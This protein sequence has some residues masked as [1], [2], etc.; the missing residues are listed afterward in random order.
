MPATDRDPKVRSSRSE[1]DPVNHDAGTLTPQSRTPETAEGWWAQH[2]WLPRI[3]YWGIH[4]SCLLA[5]G[6]GAP[7]SA[8][9]LFAITLSL[10]LLGITAGY[11]RYFSHRTYKTSRPFQLVLAVLGTMA[12]QKGPLWWA[13]HHRI[14]H[15][16]SDQPG[17]DVHS[18]K[19][20]FFYAHQ[21]WI[22]DARWNDTRLDRIRD[23]A[24][25]PELLWLNRWHIL[26]PVALA[27]FCFA[28]GG[29]AGVVWGF[30][31][32]TVVL[33]HLTYSINSLA[34][35]WGTRRYATSDTSRNNALLGLLTFGEG[36]HNNH[37]HY[38]SSVRQGFFWWEIDVTYY[39]LRTLAAAGLIWDLKQPPAHVLRGETAADLPKA[40]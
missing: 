12:T 39:V 38:A 35:R 18:P 31:I 3:V 10:R 24:R 32:S 20:G 4:A 2:Y 33:W 40:A 25:Y 26:P 19:E 34:H 1:E 22:F 15:R 5:L 36:W 21:G 7:A 28:V 16:Y 14:H 11:H 13:S 30:S 6:V 37:H 17:K 8:L 9:W 23:F 27:L 29:L